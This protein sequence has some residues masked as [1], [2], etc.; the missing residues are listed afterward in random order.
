[1]VLSLQVKC[2]KLAFKMDPFATLWLPFYAIVTIC[3]ITYICYKPH[4]IVF[5]VLNTFLNFF[6]NLLRLLYY[7]HIYHF[8]CS[9]IP[10]CRPVVKASCSILSRAPQKKLLVLLTFHHPRTFRYGWGLM[11][12]LIQTINKILVNLKIFLKGNIKDNT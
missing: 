2:E 12:I 4:I 11:N 10:S 9:S 8:K 3:M 1:M 6:E 7:L 5:F